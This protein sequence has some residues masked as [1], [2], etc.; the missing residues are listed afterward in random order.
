MTRC[1]P[2]VFSTIT[3]RKA[4]QR[5]RGALSS[6]QQASIRELCKDHYS[7]FE[8]QEWHDR[9]YPESYRTDLRSKEVWVAE[10]ETEIIG[11]AQLNQWEGR[12]EALYVLPAYTRKKIGS[13][14][15]NQLRT[16]AQ[17]YGLHT[18][19]LQ[20]SLNAVPFYTHAGFIIRERTHITLKKNLFLNCVIMEMILG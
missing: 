15:L 9:L 2:T 10:Q 11:F 8:L 20:S 4:L 17:Q 6:V 3:I 12:I 19:S 13:R 5:D 1:V 14:L 7:N 16:V 18:L